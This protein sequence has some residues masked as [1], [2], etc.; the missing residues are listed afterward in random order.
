MV[1][2]NEL[3]EIIKEFLG[4][5]KHTNFYTDGDRRVRYKMASYRDVEICRYCGEKMNL[6]GTNHKK[7]CLLNRARKVINGS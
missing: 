4:K 3:I 7:D 2:E 1:S 5:A 6:Y